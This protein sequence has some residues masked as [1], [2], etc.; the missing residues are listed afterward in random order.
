MDASSSASPPEPTTSS[1]GPAS[2]GS[3]AGAHPG[4]RRRHP[5]PVLGRCPRR[6][7]R[8]GD[9]WRPEARLRIP[10]AATPIYLGAMSPRMLELI[11][12]V[13]DG[14]LPLLYPPESFIDTMAH[15]DAGCARSGRQLDDVDVAACI[16]VSVVRRPAAGAPSVGGEA[17][18][19]RP[20]VR[21]DRARPRRGR[22]SRV[23]SPA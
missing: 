19:L 17:R 23:E 2:P 16:W 11:G 5:R 7:P 14:G 20:V 10:A 21:P 9:G 3:T 4:G 8:R 22:R 18:L 13:A 15:V 6:R 1:P 12:E